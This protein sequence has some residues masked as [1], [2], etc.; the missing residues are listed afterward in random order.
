M[1]ILCVSSREIK[2]A[3]DIKK[4]FPICEI[5]QN[6]KAEEKDKKIQTWLD[7]GGKKNF[8]FP[9]QIFTTEISVENLEDLEKVFPSFT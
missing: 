8:N 4:C 3:D 1:K 6:M 7:A 5:F 9:C 2:G